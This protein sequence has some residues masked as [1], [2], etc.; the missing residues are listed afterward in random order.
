MPYNLSDKDVRKIVRSCCEGH[1]SFPDCGCELSTGRVA[2]VVKAAWDAELTT[3]PCLV[4]RE[5]GE[6]MFVLLARNSSTPETMEKWCDLRANEIA[7][8]VRPDT[9]QERDHIEEVR[10]KAAVF[11]SWRTLTGRIDDPAS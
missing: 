3:D 11:R 1:C 4:K 9:T 10:G 6:P 2:E 5:P 8:G 7:R